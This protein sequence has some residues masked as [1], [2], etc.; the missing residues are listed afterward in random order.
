MKKE[1][2]YSEENKYLRAKEK[3]DN[4]KGFYYNIVSFCLVIPTLAFINFRFSPNQIWFYY[5]MIGWGIGILI[6][7]LYIFGRNPFISKN[8]EQN[9]IQE[10]I[11]N[12]TKAF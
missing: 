6:H 10:L 12:D 9:K 5:N 8:W 3:L 11:N 1:Y 2:K 4:L 7:A